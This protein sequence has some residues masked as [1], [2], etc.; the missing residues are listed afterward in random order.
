MEVI[1][2]MRR[3]ATCSR[4]R[5]GLAAVILICIVLAPGAIATAHAQVQEY[6]L[7]AAFLLKFGLYVE[8]PSTA[9]SSPTSPFNLCIAGQNPFGDSLD[10]AVADERINGH[11]VV[12]RQLKTV[13]RD[14]GCHI[15]YIGDSDAQHVAQIL[16]TVHGSSVLTVSDARGYGSDSG[17]ID[18]VIVNDRVRFYIDDESAAQ[19]GLVISSK[20]LS[21]ALNVKRRSSKEER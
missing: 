13:G 2:T 11:N 21:L 7:K 20:L 9:F 19:N 16:A 10:K 14:S 17:I 18:F 4:P 8:W 15:L 5:A 12:I 1:K 3:A 6:A